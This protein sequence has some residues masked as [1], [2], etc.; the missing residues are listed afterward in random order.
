MDCS[1]GPGGTV[2]VFAHP[3]DHPDPPDGVGVMS[4]YWEIFSTFDAP[5]DCALF[6]EYDEGDLNGAAEQEVAG[7]ARWDPAHARWEYVGGALYPDANMIMIDNVTAFSPWLLLTSTPPQAVSDLSGSPTGSDLQL[8]WSAVTEDLRGSGVTPDYYVVYRRADEPYFVPTPSDILATPSTPSF[9]D[10]GILGDSDHSYYYVVTSVDGAG[11][12]SAL[13]NRLGVFAYALTPAAA[14]DERAYNLIALNLEVPGVTDADTLA[15]YAGPGAYMILRHDAPTQ[16]IEWRLPG[17]AGTDFPVEV[18]GA[19][20]LYLDDT[21]PDVVS[22]VGEVPAIG[23]VGFDLTRPSP[24][25]SCAYN[26]ISVPLDRDDLVDADAL[27]A[28]IGGV[29]SV[30]RYNAATQDLTWR[31]PG[32]SGVNF[33]VRAGYPYIVCLDET[34][35]AYWP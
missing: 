32:V 22:L 33:P 18:G 12:E 35:P 3:V 4:T 1:T 34:A 10:P 5:F 27:A 24:G 15:A 16:A 30:S 28:D 26:F 8:A 20:F 25:A 31:M 13:S 11:I 17:L 21:A 19:T 6:F 14:A 9:T 2:T 23:T 29:Y 7:A